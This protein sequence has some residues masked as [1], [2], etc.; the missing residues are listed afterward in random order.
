MSI[1]AGAV[2]G[3]TH[4]TLS[5]PSAHHAFPFPSAVNPCSHARSCRRE[6]VPLGVQ[7]VLLA[8]LSVG[9]AQHPHP[10]TRISTL[11]GVLLQA[12]RVG[13][14]ARSKNAGP[15]PSGALKQL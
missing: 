14:V 4:P 7:Q 1:K 8:E 2:A 6:L 11:P 5:H 3:R 15:S 13:E 10:T 9:T 12:A